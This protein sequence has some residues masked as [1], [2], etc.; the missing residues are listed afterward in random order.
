MK[1]VKTLILQLLLCGAFV[2][3]HAQSQTVIGKEDSTWA[4]Q[5]ISTMS[6]EEKVGQLFMAPAYSNKSVEHEKEIKSLIENYHL[7]GLI[8]MKGSPAKQAQLTNTFQEVS[9]TPLLIAM[10]A[11]WGLEMRLPGTFQFPW[12]LTVGASNDSVLAYQMGVEVGKHLNRLG[13]H[14]NFAPVVDLNSNPDNPIINARSF[15]ENPNRVNKLASAY[16]AGMHSQ[17]VLACAKHFPGHGNTDSDSHK[18]LPTVNTSLG[19]LQA[20]ELAPYRDL[21]KDGLGSVMSAHLNVPALEPNNLPTSLSPRAINGY[22]RAQMGFDGLVFTDALNMKGAT[23]SF[24]TGD[25]EIQA[26]RAGNDVLLFSTD[27][28]TAFKAV[29]KEAKRNED[30]KKR[31]ERSALKVL[32]A[33][34]FTGADTKTYAEPSGIEKDLHPASSRIVRRNIY[35]KSV[36]NLINGNHLIPIQDLEDTKIALVTAGVEQSDQ[37]GTMLNKY[38]DVHRFAYQSGSE[39]QL[40]NNLNEYDIVILGYY[41]SNENPWKSYRVDP[42][43][44]SFVKKLSLQNKVILNL[45]A[46]PYSLRDFPEAKLVDGLMV[47]YQNHP[48]AEAVA[49]QIIFGALGA[50]GKLPVTVND[51]FEEG[52]GIMT[53]KLDRLGYSLPEAEGFNHQ[54]LYRKLDSLMAEAINEKATPGAQI[55]V[56]RNGKVVFNKNYGYHTYEKI[57]PVQDHHI[58]DLASITKIGATV[59]LLMKLVEEQKIDL[60]KTLGHY[61]PAAKGTN[62]ENLI[63]RDVLAHQA[64]LKPWIPF[65]L[66]TLEKGSRKEGYYAEQRSFDYPYTVAEDLYSTRHIEDTIYQDILESNLRPK[67]EYKYS[68]LGYYLFMKIIERI[69]GKSI[70]K[71]AEEFLYRPLGT[72]T[73]RYHPLRYFPEDRIVPTESDDTFR[74]QLIDGFVHDQGAALLGGVGG[75]AGLFSNAN[76]L[77]KLMQMYLQQGRYGGMTFFDSITIAEFTRCQFCEEE[78]RRGIGFDKPQFEGE[79]GPTC[80]CVSPLSFGHSGFTGTLAWA[81]PSEEIVYIFLSNRVHPDASNRKLITLD[82]R[83]KIQQAIYD[84][85]RYET[86]T[87]TTAHLSVEPASSN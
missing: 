4:L 23:N 63:L 74:K 28:P 22:L 69:E 62:K 15:G 54:Q 6:L 49:A 75:H 1:M 13:V 66:E 47:S 9:N 68:D 78:N 38:T 72:S 45:F 21:M 61:L 11:E 12:A 77:A 64:R 33:K 26:L 86:H 79:P 83:T 46:N 87:D 43:F 35:E 7:G 40:L 84:A 52:F 14:V 57:R 60:D 24:A 50:K 32:M 8:F 29:L 85:L 20:T 70:D 31:V 71:L 42:D 55:L 5:K 80:G 67:K 25:L 59:P 81:D 51:V 58:Y 53:R 3:I 48:D 56:A 2:Q 44:K 41:T 76:D 82:T 19:E 37:F 16:M 27:I 65:Y 10:D 17:N 39:F 18:T 36:T 34:S 73:M 30:F